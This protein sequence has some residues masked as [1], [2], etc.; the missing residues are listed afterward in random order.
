MQTTL[1]VWTVLQARTCLT[2]RFNVW[3]V[4][5]ERMGVQHALIQHVFAS[6]VYQASIPMQQ[7]P[8]CART[9]S[10]VSTLYIEATRTS[11]TALWAP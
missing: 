11:T 3:T 10:L 8:P 9:V 1:A 6:H 7:A 5:L 2:V 4:S